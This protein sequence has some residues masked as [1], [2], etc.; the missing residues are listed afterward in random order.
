[1]TRKRK[2]A[3]VALAPLDPAAVLAIHPRVQPPKAGAI[4]AEMID[5]DQWSYYRSG[6]VGVVKI[7]GPIWWSR[8]YESLT[9]RIGEAMADPAV[10][11]VILDIHSPGGVLHGLHEAAG[12]IRAAST[13]KPVAAFVTGMACSAAYMLAAAAGVIVA[14]DTAE[15][16]CLGVMSTWID[17]EE[18]QEEN[19]IRFRSMVSTQTP[20]KLWNPNTPEGAQRMQA[21]LDEQARIFIDRVAEMRG[22]SS[23]VVLR[24]YGAGATFIGRQAVDAGLADD[25][26]TLQ[27]MIE[28][29]N[30]GGMKYQAGALYRATSDEKIEVVAAA[31]IAGLPEVAALVEEK[32]AAA[33]STA[34]QGD[35]E[36]VAGAVAE[37]LT[38]ERA[39]VA[40]IVALQVPGAEEVC[41]KA[42]ADGTTAEQVAVAIVRAQR[43]RG[44][45]LQGMRADATQVAQAGAPGAAQVANWGDSVRRVT[46]AA[47]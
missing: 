25:V 15:L 38:A 33:K 4:D 13:R 11:S 36:A 40:A 42:I 29:R 21:Q 6:S 2:T 27:G 35:A 20:L 5:D 47:R 37:A 19:G 9:N 30:G 17:D 10:A 14:S 24:D 1:M 46:G 23:A 28:Q 45:T 7:T 34:S 22:V 31:D 32:I 8:Q 18:W 26:G 16:G 44:V 41:A 43:D 3:G 12:V 39:R